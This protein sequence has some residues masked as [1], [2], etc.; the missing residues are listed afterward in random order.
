M[1]AVDFRRTEGPFITSTKAVPGVSDATVS[2]GV[3]KTAKQLVACTYFSL[4]A[5]GTTARSALMITATA[6]QNKAVFKIANLAPASLYR[7]TCTASSPTA[8]QL[9]EKKAPVSFE[10]TTK[11]C[12]KVFFAVGYPRRVTVGVVYQS[13]MSVWSDEESPSDEMVVVVRLAVRELS[14]ADGRPV[15][16]ESSKCLLSPSIITLEGFRSL[17]EKKMVDLVCNAPG[18]FTAD[19]ILEGVASVGYSVQLLDDQSSP[20]AEWSASSA[21]AGG[22]PLMVS[23]RITSD[24]QGVRLQF[25]RAVETRAT[26]TQAS[27]LP[28]SDLFSFPGSSTASCLV[29]DSD[30]T[31]ITVMLNRSSVIMPGDEVSL[32]AGKI[33][34]LGSSSSSAHPEYSVS[35]SISVL[36]PLATKIPSIIVNSKATVGVCESVTLDFSMSTNSGGRPWLSIQ[37]TVEAY[38]TN[39]KLSSLQSFLARASGTRIVIDSQFFVAETSY[40]FNVSLCNFVQV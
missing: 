20:T 13:F 18:N 35:S 5:T 37:V 26:H 28:C 14:S 8:T 9:T 34:A 21:A 19:I 40:A 31:Y 23:A 36:V 16:K 32:R 3:D 17:S 11:C 33:L 1:L 6:L 30:S 10:F 12:K 22:A 29:G 7:L 24:L 15:V 4:N 27:V 39:V 38:P 25:D 2:I